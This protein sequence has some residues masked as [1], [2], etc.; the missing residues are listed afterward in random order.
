MA[1]EVGRERAIRGCQQV[2]EGY[3]K[4]NFSRFK[5]T[6]WLKFCHIH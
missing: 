5:V 6:Y 3:L 1:T 4:V 2:N